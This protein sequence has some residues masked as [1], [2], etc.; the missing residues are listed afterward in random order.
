MKV[1]QPHRDRCYFH[2]GFTSGAGIP[3]GDLSRLEQSLDEVK[4][5]YFLQKILEQLDRCDRAWEAS[6]LAGPEGIRFQTREKYGGDIDRGII[7][8]S[9]KDHRIWWENYL[10]EGRRLAQILWVPYYYDEASLRY[11][12]ERG[13]G[14]FINSIPGPADTSS[15]TRKY[16]AVTLAGAFG[17]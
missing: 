9:S 3:A 8:E 13:D 17:F 1:P 6:E 12:F 2:L 14:A 11:R 16:W 4:S 15:G 10:A 7:R 5:D